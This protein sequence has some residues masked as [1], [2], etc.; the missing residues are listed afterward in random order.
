[1]NSAIDVR[2]CSHIPHAMYRSS[3]SSC[4]KDRESF[5]VADSA[6]GFFHKLGVSK[7]G[8]LRLAP[9]MIEVTMRY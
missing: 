7:R 9:L 5:G 4:S 8:Y 6:R 1:M 2:C 3:C